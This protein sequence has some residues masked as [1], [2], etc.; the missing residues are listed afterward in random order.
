MTIW[1][2][3]LDWFTPSAIRRLRN[4]LSS[5]RADLASLKVTALG[6]S[7]PS[8]GVDWATFTDNLLEKVDLAVTDKDAELGWQCFKAARRF[9]LFGIAE[10][11]PESL[12]TRATMVLNEAMEPSKGLSKWRQDSIKALLTDQ[13]GKLKDMDRTDVAQ[14]VEAQHILDEHQDNVYARLSMFMSRL[15]LL[16]ALGMAFLFVWLFILKPPVPQ[17]VISGGASDL[18]APVAANVTSGGASTPS[19]SVGATAG[20]G[21]AKTPS[22]PTGVTAASGGASTSSASTSA[23]A[24]SADASGRP[25]SGGGAADKFWWMVVMAGLLGGLIS[26]FTSTVGTDIKK[27]T[28]PAELSTQTITFSRLV[29]SALSALA[30]TLF[31]CS[32]ILSF[33]ELSYA[34]ILAFAVAAGFTDRLLINTI[35]RVAPPS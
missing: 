15:A 30:I 33:K 26:A 25:G 10:V 3:F 31:L 32:G 24:A 4:A 17:I 21:G 18:L 34:L 6:Q 14:L 35:N 22:A 12:K 27:S 11:N 28:I 20:S 8:S 9:M 29:V 23:T 1:D 5:F 7:P 13:N 2:R 19:A 16:A